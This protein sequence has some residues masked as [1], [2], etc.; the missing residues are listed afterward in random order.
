LEFS[1]AFFFCVVQVSRYVTHQR[2]YH[3]IITR[4][5]FANF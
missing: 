2:L 3:T 4:T 1:V 5:F